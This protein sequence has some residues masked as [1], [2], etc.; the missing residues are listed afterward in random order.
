MNSPHI[1]VMLNEVLHYLA[2]QS[3]EIIVDATFGAGGYSRAIL[4]K[5]ECELHSI[6]K[7]PAAN[8]RALEVKANYGERFSFHQGS[9][10]D[11]AALVANKPV[12]GI[13]F[14]LGVSSMQLDEGERGFS[15]GKDGPLDMRMSKSGETAADVVNNLSVEELTRIISLYG[16]ERYALKVARAIIAARPLYTTLELAN[17]VRKVV[18]RTPG[19]IDSATRTFQGLRIY[20]NR[21]LEEL[22][23]GLRA[24]EKIL[25]PGGKL[26][27][28][29][30]HSL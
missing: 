26:V 8:S 3:G 17:V 29:S 18:F 4:D 24:A 11:L 16:E 28:V 19:G 21:E 22:E 12:D 6:D 13:V 5:A 20:V 9:F 30:F 27:V 15:F 14:D 1:P 2:P 7:D 10:S 23:A 25:K